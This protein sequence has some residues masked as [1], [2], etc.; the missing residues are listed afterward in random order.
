MQFSAR[1]GTTAAGVGLVGTGVHDMLSSRENRAGFGGAALNTAT[2]GVVGGGA[3]GVA[4]MLRK[5]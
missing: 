2:M 4:A 5:L 3:A 1:V